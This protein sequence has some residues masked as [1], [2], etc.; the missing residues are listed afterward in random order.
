MLTI[1]MMDRE[2]AFEDAVTRLCVGR[3]GTEGWK[4]DPPSE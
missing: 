2:V 4:V 3:S 1:K